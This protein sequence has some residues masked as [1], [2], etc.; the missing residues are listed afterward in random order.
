MGCWDEGGF[1]EFGEECANCLTVRQSTKSNPTD[2]TRAVWED[3]QKYK[4]CLTYVCVCECFCVWRS[5][6]T[7]GYLLCSRRWETPRTFWHARRLSFQHSHL[8]VQ[9]Q[10]SKVTSQSGLGGSQSC[11]WPAAARESK[12]KEDR[13]TGEEKCVCLDGKIPT[14][15]V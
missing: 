9:L 3:L 14:W 8:S 1:R 5:K 15:K 13:Q 2:Q 4:M 10:G 6:V 11:W 12:R 7:P